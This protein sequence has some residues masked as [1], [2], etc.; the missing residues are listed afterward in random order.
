MQ[1]LP[2]AL[3]TALE[4]ATAAANVVI[5]QPSV[6][7]Q[8]ITEWAKQA[9]CWKRVQ[10]LTVEWPA[11]IDG[12][13]VMKDDADGDRRSARLEKKML[14]G[15]E[16]QSMAVRAGH[17]FWLEV[18]K[19]GRTN[20]RL[21]PTDAGIIQALSTPGKI[22]S[23]KQCVRAIELLT[24]MQAEGCNLRLEASVPHPPGQSR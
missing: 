19:W 16:A 17:A 1:K 24:A 5:T 3:R 14:S 18:L 12:A 15:I 23:E 21:S 13:L 9:A 20:F 6:A 10:D 4:V 7:S 8:S 22:G 2:K 11:D